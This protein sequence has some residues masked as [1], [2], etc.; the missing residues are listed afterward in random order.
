MNK[1]TRKK[2]KIKF[3]NSVLWE[4]IKFAQLDKPLFTFL[5]IWISATVCVGL[6][7]F[8]AWSYKTQGTVPLDTIVVIILG[9]Q[10]FFMLLQTINI[11]SH[12]KL[13]KLVY[14]PHIHVWIVKPKSQKY[15]EIKIK[16]NGTD[17]VNV[18]YAVNDSWLYEKNIIRESE[19][20]F[21][22]QK[23]EKKLTPQFDIKKYQPE[24]LYIRVWYE[25]L[26]NNK[27]FA[28]YKKKRGELSLV[29]ITTGLY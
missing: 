3:F 24:Q 18:K 9:F 10:V 20:A 15:F 13:A 5:S 27:Y 17:A 19:S 26:L 7:Y 16:N 14:L 25:D 22:L 4:R 6:V 11:I 28:L 8:F 23:K 21:S 2:R 29:N 1:S 12:N